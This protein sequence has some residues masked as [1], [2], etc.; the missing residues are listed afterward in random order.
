MKKD[1]VKLLEEL[2]NCS[3]FKE[4]HNKNESEI[5]KKKVSDYL[6]KLIDKKS[7]KKSDIV[8]S[9]EMSEVYAYQILSGVRVPE[10]NKLLCIAFGM[11]LSFEEVQNLLK[12]TGYAPLYAKNPFDCILIY[13]FCKGMNIIEANTLLYDYGEET[14]G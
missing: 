2:K 12:S 13:A 6:N 7:L 5:E 8:K 3:D 9:S 1:T 11:G 10:R 4:F 14:L